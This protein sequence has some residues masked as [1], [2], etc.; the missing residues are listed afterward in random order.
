MTRLYTIINRYK[1][2]AVS[3][4]LYPL[5]IYTAFYSRSCSGRKNSDLSIT[6]DI[7]I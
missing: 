1:L 4:N 2:A 7:S 6:G 5:I 3:S